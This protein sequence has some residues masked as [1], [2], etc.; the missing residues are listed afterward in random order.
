[1][2][3]KSP[4]GYEFNRDDRLSSSLL[5]QPIIIR[6]L[7][8]FLRHEPPRDI[9]KSSSIHQY[10]VLWICLKGEGCL[11]VN[12]ISYVLREKNA[13][14][15]FPAQQHQRLP[16]D[17]KK[18]DWL[19]IRFSADCPRWF[20]MF[21][22]RVIRLSQKSIGYLK[23]FSRHYLDASHEHIPDAALECSYYLGLLL[24]SLRTAP[25]LS[26]D[27]VQPAA[28][29]N[30]YVRQ[31]CQLIISP[32]LTDRSYQLIARKIGISPAYLRELFKKYVGLTPAQLIKSHQH[33]AM[34]NLLL[35]SSMNISQ[36]AE[37]CGYDNV[38]SF[39]RYF[40]KATGISPKQFRK[41]YRH[42]Q[43]FQ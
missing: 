4:K 1:M 25:E 24:N 43:E 11:M 22:N 29:G 7:Q 23:L 18:A 12:G 26:E 5:V 8:A 36:I 33:K 40:K 32:E 10:Y 31:A 9:V 27:A 34:Q 30:D 20:N 42:T 2:K 3:L 17:N 35:N 39:S 38:Y 21:Q 15:T 37:K 19:L 41:K 16:M 14:I 28:S 13:I 6:Q